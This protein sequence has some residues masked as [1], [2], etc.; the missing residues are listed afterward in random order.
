MAREPHLVHIEQPMSWYHRSPL[1]K[2]IC[3]MSGFTWCSL[4]ANAVFCL[5][6]RQLDDP[7]FLPPDDTLCE[8]CLARMYGRHEPD[9]T[10]IGVLLA[11][12]VFPLGRD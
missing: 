2:T 6:M 5:E 8:D 4:D 10:V 1:M 12:Y 7:H 9:D 3:P 11:K